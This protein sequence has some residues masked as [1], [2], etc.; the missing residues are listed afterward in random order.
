MPKRFERGAHTPDVPFC[1]GAYAVLF[2]IRAKV[3]RMIMETDRLFLREI[4]PADFPLLCRHLQD[5]E[6]MYAYTRI[7]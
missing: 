4:T 3:V 1:G 7:R 2:P 5:A 6:V